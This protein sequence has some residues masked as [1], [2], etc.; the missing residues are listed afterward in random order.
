LAVTS[1]FFFFSNPPESAAFVLT[2]TIAPQLDAAQ[3]ILIKTLLNKGVENELIAS[4]A[5]CSVR[6][7]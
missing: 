3:H 6:A 1:S 5:L 4:E 2:T 7:V